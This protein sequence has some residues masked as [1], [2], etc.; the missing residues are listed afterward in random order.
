MGVFDD[1]RRIEAQNLAFAA[2]R[3]EAAGRLDEAAQGFARAA[4][5]EEAVACGV[6]LE[7]RRTRT[8]LAVSAAALWVRGAR[9]RDAIRVA[10]FFLGQLDSLT[11]EG[12]QELR[13]LMERAW[14]AGDVEAIVQDRR[15]VGRIRLKLVDGRVRHGLVPAGIARQRQMLVTGLVLRAAEYN[16]GRPYRTQGA[17]GSALAHPLEIYEGPA[18]AASYGLNLIVLPASPQ[19][20]LWPDSSEAV[21]A[22]GALETFLA[23]CRTAS[24]AEEPGAMIPPGE[25]D[26]FLGFEAGRDYAT[27]V[28][29]QIKQLAADGQ[30]VGRVVME[31]SVPHARAARLALDPVVRTRV[32]ARIASIADYADQRELDVRLVGLVFRKRVPIVRVEL[33][34]RAGALPRGHRM[35]VRIDQRRIRRFDPDWQDHLQDHLRETARI[36]VEYVPGSRGRRL[37]YLVAYHGLD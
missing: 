9:H 1:P 23:W 11:P 21:T 17:P 24:E 2:E 33:L 6:P 13:R 20:D 19:S 7:M 12:I 34:T 36:T 29:R 26:P 27:P 31:T 25:A 8:T 28:L 10:G 4:E 37:P 14:S 5:L 30:D 18:E 35:D 3:A 32:D 22:R 15:D 16:E